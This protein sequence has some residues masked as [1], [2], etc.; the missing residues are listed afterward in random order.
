MIERQRERDRE[1]ERQREK[2]R[3]RQKETERDRGRGERMCVWERERERD[4][5]NCFLFQIVIK[6]S[7]FS[8][9]FEDQSGAFWITISCYESPISFAIFIFI[10]I[11]QIILEIVVDLFSNLWNY[12][13]PFM[14]KYEYTNTNITKLQKGFYIM[15]VYYLK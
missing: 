11:A 1:R 9:K 15:R 8:P 2:D 10:K 13:T 7:N 5:I 14:Y 4:P 6:K 3:K 12:I